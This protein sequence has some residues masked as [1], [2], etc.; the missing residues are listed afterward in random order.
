MGGVGTM[1]YRE[2]QNKFT[3]TSKLGVTLEGHTS[4]GKEKGRYVRL[5]MQRDVEDLRC[6]TTGG[7]KSSGV[8]RRW[9]RSV[10]P[11]STFIEFWI[12]YDKIRYDKLLEV[13]T[14]SF[15]KYT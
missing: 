7:E 14:G 1:Q 4:L 2:G 9:R 11:P 5:P 6:C 13:T 10:D 3:R 12:V 15:Y 8:S